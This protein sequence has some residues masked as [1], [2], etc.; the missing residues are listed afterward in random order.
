MATKTLPDKFHDLRKGMRSRLVERDEEIEIFLQALLSRSHAFFLGEPGIAKSLLV[1]SGVS[2]INGLSDRDY[3]HILFMKSTT[4]EDVFGPLSITAFKQDRYKFL[5][6]GYLPD[7]KIV[8]GDEFWKANGAIQNALLWATNERKYRND[9]QIIDLPLH[10]MFIASNELPDDD[11]LLAI[12]DRF[13]L[14]KKVLPIVEPGAFISMLNLDSTPIKPV[15]DWNDVEAAANEVE[16]VVIPPSVLDEMVELKQKLKDLSILPSDR[17]WKQSLKIVRAAAWLDGE[18]TAD[19]EHLRPLRFVLWSDPEEFTAVENLCLELANPIDIEITKIMTDLSKLNAELDKIIANP[20]DTENR[21]RQGTAVYD[22][23]RAA[24]D[25]LVELAGKL[26]DS[27]KR[28]VK[29]GPA[30][31]QVTSLT[32]RMLTKVF[33]TSEEEISEGLKEFTAIDADDTEE[34]ADGEQ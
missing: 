12:Y 26:K 2:L 19:I 7:A 3:F 4:R 24:K 25:E 31:D 22:K 11:A 15:I 34:T 28:S 30:A 9:G 27:K 1:E 8:F 21:Q 5:S 17:R 10:S 20:G 33:E 18:T 6:E 16:N 14:R 32:K 23:I 29:L 13:P